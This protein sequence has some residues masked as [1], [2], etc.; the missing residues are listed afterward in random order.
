MYDIAQT[1]FVRRFN[2][3]ARAETKADWALITLQMM[4]SPLWVPL[5]AL[6]KI[7]KAA[8]GL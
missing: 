5:W 6:Y 8:S 4:A 7:V 2:A 3:A 1:P